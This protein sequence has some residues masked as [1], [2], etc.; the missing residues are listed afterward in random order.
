MWG[1][2]ISRGPNVFVGYLKR[3]GGNDRVLT[4]TA[5]FTAVTP[6]SWMKRVISGQG[7]KK[8]DWSGRGKPE[9]NYIDEALR[10]VPAQ[11]HATSEC[12]MNVCRA[13]MCVRGPRNRGLVGPAPGAVPYEGKHVPKRYWPERLEQIKEI[14]RTGSG[15]KIPASWKI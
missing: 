5:G 9:F 4:E 14:P 12:R 2:E 1:E 10:G 13:Y 6:A 8:D 3:P 15:K 11:D 7:R